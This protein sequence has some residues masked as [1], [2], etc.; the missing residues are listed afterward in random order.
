MKSVIHPQFDECK[1]Y[2]LDRYWKEIFEACSQNK[3]PRGMGYNASDNILYV[4]PK[5][6]NKRSSSYALPSD[7]KDLFV[8]M[9][10]LFRTN[11]RMTSELDLKMKKSELEEVKKNKNIDLNCEWKD[12]KTKSIKDLL[13]SRWVMDKKEEMNL[14]SQQAKQL[15]NTIILGMN[16]KSLNFS[17]FVFSEGVLHNINGIKYDD[18]TKMFFL[19]NE[20]EK[21]SKNS[22][23]NTTNLL[24]KGMEKYYNSKVK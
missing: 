22:K 10:D 4:K 20:P 19:E 5:G 18:E 12:I 11:L 2:T 17:D 1:K 14:T 16:V 13:I 23:N 15:Y 6:S 21:P 3:F 7:T 9:M 8:L 24:V